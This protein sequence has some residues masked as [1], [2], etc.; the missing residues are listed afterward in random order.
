VGQFVDDTQLRLARYD[1]ADVHLLQ[2]DPAVLHLAARNDFQVRERGFRFGTS[3]RFHEPHHDVY[4]VAAQRVRVLDHRVGLA[5]ARRGA[6]VDP[7]AGP[8][9]C[10]ELRQR[11]VAGGPGLVGH[12]PIVTWCPA[13]SWRLYQ[14]FMPFCRI[15]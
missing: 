3:V 5:H 8:L 1:R 14:L 9:F 4:A 2:D 10:L 15:S 12:A 13:R 11:L 6:D 7:Q